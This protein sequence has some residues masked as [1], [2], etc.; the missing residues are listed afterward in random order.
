MSDYQKEQEAAS[1]RQ[2]R[3]EKRAERRMRRALKQETASLLDKVAL[4][5]AQEK[6]Q[7]TL[8]AERD[9]FLEREWYV[10]AG[11]AKPRGYR[12]GFAKPR[13]RCRG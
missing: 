12:N 2:E 9:E 6:I 13:S 4:V 11:K 7:D 1:R 3:R 8:E 10:R 5:G